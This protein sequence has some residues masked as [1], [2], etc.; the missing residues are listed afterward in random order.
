MHPE[1]SGNA[2]IYLDN[3]DV[4][5]VPDS[6]WTLPPERVKP[7]FD[8]D[9]GIFKGYAYSFS[10][11]SQ[12]P[13]LLSVDTVA[14][15]KMPSPY[16]I[17]WGVGTVQALSKPA[18]VDLALSEYTAQFFYQGASLS[19]LVTS[20][21]ALSDLDFERIKREVRNELLGNRNAHK[22]AVLDN[23]AM[24]TPLSMALKDIGIE[25]LKDLTLREILLGFGI[26]GTKLGLLEF[27][28]YK[29]EEAAITFNEDVMEPR[30]R[31]VE[32]AL[33]KIARMYDVDGNPVSE[34]EMYALQYGLPYTGNRRG[35]SIELMLPIKDYTRKRLAW[36]GQA[37][38][39]QDLTLEERRRLIFSILGDLVQADKNPDL[40]TIPNFQT[41]DLQERKLEADIKLNQDKVK[42]QVTASENSLK[43]S[44]NAAQAN[45]DKAQSQV[46]ANT[47]QSKGAESGNDG[48]VNQYSKP[49]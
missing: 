6:I 22:I 23:G 7:H 44:K 46:N 28:G 17:Y 24:F 20:K 14:H 36:A 32:D 15:I 31:M 33:N 11:G 18:N 26:P 13:H 1:I 29:S 43:A 4:N 12:E 47:P 21:E 5:G 42:A 34:E 41:L 10:T 35:L 19:G 45:A 38:T 49:R 25:Q 2:L 8:K 37:S 27:A 3:R 16:S 48:T 40:S 39:L 30:V 9:T